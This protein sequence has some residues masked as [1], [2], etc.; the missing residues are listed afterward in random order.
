MKLS[1]AAALLG[2]SEMAELTKM[3]LWPWVA[4]EPEPSDD[5]RI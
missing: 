3:L 4:A 1:L 5:W 2:L